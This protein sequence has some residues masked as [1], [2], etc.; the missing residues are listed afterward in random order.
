MLFRAVDIEYLKLNKRSIEICRFSFSKYFSLL[1]L[2]MSSSWTKNCSILYGLLLLRAKCTFLFYIYGFFTSR[3]KNRLTVEEIVDTE[4]VVPCHS[5]H[6]GY[7]L[8][9]KKN[10]VVQKQRPDFMKP[11]EAKTF[12]KNTLRCREK[13]ER[14][15]SNIL[16]DLVL[17]IQGSVLFFFMC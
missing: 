16:S 8:R 9:S 3:K 17:C 6:S 13:K 11:M 10:A 5:T 7:F 14:K 4:R 15:R 12:E 1:E 2:E